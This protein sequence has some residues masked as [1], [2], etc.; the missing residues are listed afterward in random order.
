MR[1][2]SLWADGGEA[3]LVLYLIMDPV[4]ATSILKGYKEP[5]WY[6]KDHLTETPD[7]KYTLYFYNVVEGSMMAYYANLA[8]FAE[9]KFDSPLLSSG[10]V[11]I[12]YRTRKP[13][14]YA[15]RSE[16]FI[17]EMPADGKL[18]PGA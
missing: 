9:D 11:W 3:I 12:W 16:C 7:K 10:D 17:L 18:K 6:A 4:I 2:G 14:I 8:V 1:L 5:Q 15:Q 13:F